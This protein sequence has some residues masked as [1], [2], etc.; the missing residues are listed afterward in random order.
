MPPQ[1]DS[2]ERR[3]SHRDLYERMSVL[4]T[5]MIEARDDTREMK[6]YLI[7][8]NGVPPLIPTLEKR[9]GVVEQRLNT[10]KAW[11][12]GAG[13]VVGGIITLIGIAAAVLKAA[14]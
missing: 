1:S 8:G 4:E 13:W 3:Q 5:L 7:I 10:A 6:Q 9:V 11:V 12:K 2:E 14:L